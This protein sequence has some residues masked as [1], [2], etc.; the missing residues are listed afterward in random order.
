MAILLD[1]VVRSRLI[2]TGTGRQTADTGQD[3]RG[4]ADPRRQ[5]RVER[6]A[7]V[8]TGFESPGQGLHRSCF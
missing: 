2:P 5:R 3:E 4:C 7:Q 8:G 1:V 6:P